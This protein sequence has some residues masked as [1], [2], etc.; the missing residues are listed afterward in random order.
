M[1]NQTGTL[2]N[3]FKVV[4]Y[5]IMNIRHLVGNTYK[6]MITELPNWLANDF[7]VD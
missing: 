2:Q 5:V 1:L 3:T 4:I 6:V 7:I